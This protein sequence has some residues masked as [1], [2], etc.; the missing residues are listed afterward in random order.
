MEDIEAQ[1]LAEAVAAFQVNCNYIKTLVEQTFPC[2]I[3]NG[4]CPYFYKV[5]V[6]LFFHVKKQID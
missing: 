3:L 4:M 2:I 5:K 6:M 1:L